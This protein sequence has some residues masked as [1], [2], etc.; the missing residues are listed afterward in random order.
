MKTRA[1]KEAKTL[2]YWFRN[3]Y[4]LPPTDPR[5]LD[6]TEAEIEMEYQAHLYRSVLDKGREPDLDEFETA[7]IDAALEKWAEEDDEILDAYAE[8]G[9]A[10][11]WEEVSIHE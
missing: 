5:Y 3:K 2:R 10:G 9:I 8:R 7:E 11:A 1:L 4:R 6:M